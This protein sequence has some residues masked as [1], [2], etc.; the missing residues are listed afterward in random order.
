M[1][2]PWERE[3]AAVIRGDV[4]GAAPALVRC[5]G[6]GSRGV[7]AAAGAGQAWLTRTP[8]SSVCKKPP[9]SYKIGLWKPSYEAK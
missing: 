3:H 5:R 2:R 8:D 9:N 4:V 6:N 7:G 1:R